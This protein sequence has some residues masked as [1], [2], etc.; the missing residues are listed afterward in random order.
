M[1]RI[2]PGVRNDESG[3][4]GR[5]PNSGN[6]LPNVLGSCN[7]CNRVTG[8][9]KCLTYKGLWIWAR[10]QAVTAV[11]KRCNPRAAWRNQAQGGV[12][13]SWQVIAGVHV[14]EV[15]SCHFM[16]FQS[17]HFGGGVVKG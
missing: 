1:E 12:C 4:E 7:R 13:P 2:R 8:K 11:T 17:F 6:K 14:E 9:H 15:I 5:G 10:L 3:R 16:S